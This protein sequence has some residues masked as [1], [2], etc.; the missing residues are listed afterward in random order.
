[1]SA[2]D[3]G[4]HRTLDFIRGRLV[5]YYAGLDY[6]SAPFG[7]SEAVLSRIWRGH[8]LFLKALSLVADHVVIPPTFFFYSCPLSPTV[9]VRTYVNELAPLFDGRVLLSPVYSG[10]GETIEFLDLKQEWGSPSERRLIE[11]RR[12]SLETLFAQVPLLHREVS[13]QSAGFEQEF[14]QQSRLLRSRTTRQKAAELLERAIE[15]QIYGDVS[16][17]RGAV[18]TSLDVNLRKGA[19]TKREYRTLYY[20]MN[21]AYYYAGTSTYLDARISMLDAVKHTPMLRSFLTGDSPRMLVAYDPQVVLEVLNAHGIS[22][23]DLDLLPSRR[24]LQIRSRPEFAAFRDRYAE[25]ARLTQDAVSATSGLTRVKVDALRTGFL[26]EF[27]QEHK[28]ERDAFVRRRTAWTRVVDVIITALG[29]VVG[30]VIAGPEQRLLGAVVGAV[31]LLPPAIGLADKVADR[32][33][34]RLGGGEDSF[35]RFLRSLRAV[36]GEIRG[37]RAD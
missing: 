17:S 8:C 22:N 5:V 29:G 36:V 7:E 21:R 18:I 9:T 3:F 19:I 28:A 23:E 4:Y 30:G 31:G 10:L 20:A 2:T 24:I 35:H 26:A 33:V 15:A 32:L 27:K 6:K 14:V 34:D 37:T 1:M 16:L 13:M 11:Q 25:F 12:A